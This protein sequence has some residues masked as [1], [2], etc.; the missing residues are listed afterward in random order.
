MNIKTF[1]INI[2]NYDAQ[3]TDIL[4]LK[5]YDLFRNN[6]RNSRALKILAHKWFDCDVSIYW[7]ANKF[8]KTE[9]TDKEIVDKY[10]TDYY[11]IA[12][13]LSVKKNCVYE[14]IK[15]AKKRINDYEELHI[16]QTQED[17]YR[18]SGFPENCGTLAGFQPLIRRHN[19][20][21]QRFNE[22]WWAEI[23]RFSYRDQVSFPVVLARHPELRVNFCNVNS[24][25]VKK[26]K[27]HGTKVFPKII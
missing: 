8:N 21:T 10:L 11:D 3:R 25:L 22:D 17:Y 26:K 20:R 27:S 13:Q 14:E 12:V 5:D 2:G 19:E 16:L 9:L 6:A 23:C 1:T 7:D 24:D 18:A 4:C 15:E